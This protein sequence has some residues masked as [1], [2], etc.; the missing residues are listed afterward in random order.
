[1]F[2]IVNEAKTALDLLENAGFKAYLVGGCV[3]D[4]ILGRTFNDYDI[5]T[6]ALPEQI[7]NVF[8]SYRVIE[9][10]IKHGTV[11]VL[12]NGL[13]FEITTF[14][15]DGEYTDNRHPENVIFSTSISDDL[16]RRDFTV[17]AMAYNGKLIDFFGGIE[18][19]RGKIIRCVGDPDKRFNEDGLRIMRALRFASVLGFDIEENTSDSILRN[20]HL[21]KNISRERICSE[22]Q[23]L[24]TGIYAEKI[25]KK[26]AEVFDE[27]FM[28]KNFAHKSNYLNVQDAPPVVAFSVFFLHDNFFE[29]DLKSLK[30][31]NEVYYNCCKVIK[32]YNTILTPD[33]VFIKRFLNE[34][35]E[36]TY[37]HLSDLQKSQ[38]I[39]NE[40][41]DRIFD[42]IITEGECYT[43][44]RLNINGEILKRLG[45]KDRQIGIALKKL[46]DAVIESS[47]QNEE[48]ELIN[49]T[50][51]N[52]I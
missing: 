1:M 35:G 21:L 9:T 48:N 39:N 5:T 36:K 13:P 33:K 4:S 31:S 28:G 12:I 19:L 8:S 45:L 18:D 50:K 24:I 14:R 22:L 41:S 32:N 16:S 25:I 34:Y 49:Y 51:E 44:D 15:I 26:Y 40:L 29:E 20:K 3:R 27:I 17:N 11:T 46:L 43:I 10:G 42:N 47:V 30:V 23:K 6:N 52:L 37:K 7:K 2:D 38:G